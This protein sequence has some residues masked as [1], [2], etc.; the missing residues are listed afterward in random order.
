MDERISYFK[1]W[2]AA[3]N[4]W[5]LLRSKNHQT[6]VTAASDFK[7]FHL[8]QSEAG[9]APAAVASECQLPV[10]QVSVS[11]GAA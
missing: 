2:V 4:I 3:R 11:F 7:A 5:F 10:E 6:V 9:T 8:C 1:I